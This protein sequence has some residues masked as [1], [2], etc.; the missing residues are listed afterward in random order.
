MKSQT[1]KHFFPNLKY[2]LVAEFHIEQKK[3]KRK[4][5]G[6]FQTD[7][8]I[9]CFLYS[10]SKSLKNIET[11]N[12]MRTLVPNKWVIRVYK[13]ST[14]KSIHNNCSYLIQIKSFESLPPFLKRVLLYSHKYIWHLHCFFPLPS[15][16]RPLKVKGKE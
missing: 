13:R 16:R 9:R 8:A 6:P 14:M 3:E 1:R 15:L 5:L 2:F 11:M 4:I 12:P 7:A 10:W